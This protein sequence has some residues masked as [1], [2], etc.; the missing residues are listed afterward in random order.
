MDWCGNE[1]VLLPQYPDRFDSEF[2]GCLF[3]ISK[4]AI[5]SHI[6]SIDRNPIVHSK[7]ELDSK[8]IEKQ[9]KGFQGYEAI[10]FNGQ[11]VYLAIEVENSGLMS[12]YIIKGEIDSNKTIIKLISNSLKE[13]PLPVKLENM[14][15][16]TLL[17]VKDRVVAIYEA[18]GKNVNAQ[19]AVMSF[20]LDLQ[21]HEILPFP[22][23]EYRIT[24][25]TQID[26]DKFWTINYLYKGDKELL[27]P[28]DDNFAQKPIKNNDIQTV[29]RLVQF[30][31]NNNEIKLINQKPVNI[32]LSQ[33]GD[34]RNW[35]GIVK[36]DSLGFIL[37]T[38][39]FPETILAYIQYSLGIN[40]LFIIEK[41]GKFGFKNSLNNT[42]IKPQYNF[43]QDF[44]KYGLA[45]VVDDSGWVYINKQGEKIIRP[46]VVD[47]GPDY[48]AFGL[49][50]FKLNNKYGYFDARGNIIIQPQF[51]FAR[52][53]ADSI[54]AVCQGCRHIN[55]GEH[56]E[57]I[58]GKWGFINHKG[59]VIIP[60]KFQHVKDFTG[61]N[62]SVKL[63]DKWVTIDKNGMTIK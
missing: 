8:G 1:L 58:S 25:A 9:I 38:D 44:S 63:G 20:D 2:N 49:A 36:Y 60:Y 3:Y 18:N 24:D 33:N 22:N 26:K 54:A 61:G 11:D 59:N 34:S 48:F 37:I 7:I 42:I 40:D 43:A 51:D 30:Q 14:A 32:K 19:P 28:A 57:I 6:K 13:I 50:R 4:S 31:I 41:N 35:E 10:V 55:K 17:I 29:E 39:K 16:E 15:I 52:P 21:N 47:N 45:A 46:H 5:T 62:A 27:N 23:I 53:Y 56:T 12:A